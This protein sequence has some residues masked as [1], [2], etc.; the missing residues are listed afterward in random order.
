MVSSRKV[1]KVRC[2]F[3]VAVLLTPCITSTTQTA[4][5][6]SG[7]FF[8]LNSSI[9]LM[10]AGW[11]LIRSI[12]TVLSK[13]I[14]YHLNRFMR[15]RLLFLDSF[16]AFLISFASFSEKIPV[17]S[18]IEPFPCA[19]FFPFILPSVFFRSNACLV[20]SIT[21]VDLDAMQKYCS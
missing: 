16:M 5:V 19:A 17:S 6:D 13:S 21:N 7:S 4:A 14:H 2:S 11:W 10:A 15:A 9:F 20:S 12:K 8:H 18:R 3:W 1:S